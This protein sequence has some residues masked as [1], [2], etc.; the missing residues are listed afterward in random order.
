MNNFPRAV[1]AHEERAFRGGPGDGIGTLA[2]ARINWDAQLRQDVTGEK[3][4]GEVIE[5]RATAA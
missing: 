5:P 4:R 3:P 1:G 2:F